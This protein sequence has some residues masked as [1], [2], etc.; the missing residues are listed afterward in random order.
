MHWMNFVQMEVYTIQSEGANKTLPH[1]EAISTV[2][3]N[4][5]FWFNVSISYLELNNSLVLKTRL[6]HVTLRLT[7]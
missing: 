3:T 7:N 1:A 2:Q 4:V 6:K 5:L